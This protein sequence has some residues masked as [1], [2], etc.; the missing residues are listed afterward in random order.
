MKYREQRLEKLILEQL[1]VLVSR[2]LEFEGAL[3]TL[4]AVEMSEDAEHARIKV[5][6]WPSEKKDAV[7]AVLK[8]AQGRMQYELMKKIPVRSLP[9][10]EFVYD[11]GSENAAGVEKALLEQ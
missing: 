4:T 6:V 2:E 8:D 11:R 7:M 10:I 3:P 9:R 5:S 1:A